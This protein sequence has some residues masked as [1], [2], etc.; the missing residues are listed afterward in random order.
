MGGTGLNFLKTRQQST[1]FS[2]IVVPLVAH[3]GLQHSVPLPN[4]DLFLLGVFLQQFNN[5]NFL[6]L[7]GTPANIL[8]HL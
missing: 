1:S 7:Y 6:A 4:L 5:F 2:V 3:L 8:R